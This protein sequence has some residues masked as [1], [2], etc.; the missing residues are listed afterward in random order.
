M[1]QALPLVGPLFPLPSSPISLKTK[2]EKPRKARFS[3]STSNNASAEE[4]RPILSLADYLT[5]PGEAPVAPERHNKAKKSKKNKR[6]SSDEQEH[7]EAQKKSRK[8]HSLSD[9]DNSAE[10]AGF[11]PTYTKKKTLPAPKKTLPAWLMADTP[12]GPWQDRSSGTTDWPFHLGGSNPRPRNRD[13]TPMPSD[14]EEEFSNQPAPDIILEEEQE[15][16]E[17]PVQMTEPPNYEAMNT[18][19]SLDNFLAALNADDNVGPNVWPSVA[20]LVEKS[21]NMPHKDEIKNLYQ[22]HKRPAN[23]PSLEKVTLDSEIAAGLAER[24]PA[25]RKTDASLGFVNNAVV[26]AAVCLTEIMNTNM[27][28]MSPQEMAKATMS[29]AFDALRILAYGNS[30]LHNTRRHLLKFALDPALRQPLCKNAS[31]ESINSTHQLFGGDMQKKA[32]E[33]WS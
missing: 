24:F 10:F 18:D 9:S 25:A 15:H 11:L 30:H 31:L 3:F 28:Q 20:A 32:K 8:T 2:M 19:I 1:E 17:E 27:T 12:P 7:M 26:K 21:W 29:K 16:M 33:G 22:T 23:T 5:G 4:D 14:S 13:T 6:S